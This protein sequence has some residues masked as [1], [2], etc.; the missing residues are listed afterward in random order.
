MKRKDNLTDYDLL[1]KRY[2]D[3]PMN[4]IWDDLIQDG[5]DR[6]HGHS[7]WRKKS[8]VL[9]SLWN[10]GGLNVDIADTEARILKEEIEEKDEKILELNKKID[11]YKKAIIKLE[12]KLE[13]PK[14]EKVSGRNKK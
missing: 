13:G 11:Y 4:D 3:K 8:E 6:S 10:S 12:K 9:K 14:D 7:M 5:E 1:V 2:K